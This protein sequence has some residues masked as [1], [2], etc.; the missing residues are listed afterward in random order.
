MSGFVFFGKVQLL[1][2]SAASVTDAADARYISVSGQSSGGSMAIQHLFAYSSQIKGAAIAAGSPYACGAF[3]EGHDDRKGN[4][5]GTCY[6]GGTNLQKAHEYIQQ[7]FKDGLI[8]NPANLK[9]IPVVVFNGKNDWCVYE[10]VSRDIIKQLEQYSGLGMIKRELGTRAAHVWSLDHFPSG[11][12]H[13][14]CGKCALY[15]K[16]S[17]PCCDFNNCHYDLSGD[18]LK[19]TYGNKM[20]KQRTTAT[21]SFTFINQRLYLPKQT[22]FWSNALVEKWAVAYVPSGCKGRTS[23]CDIHINYHGCINNNWPRRRMWVNGLDLNEY[24]EANN[25]IIIY[26]QAA[27]NKKTG[28]GCWNWGFPQFDQLYDTKESVQM[29]MVMNIVAHFRQDSTL[30]AGIDLPLVGQVGI[31]L[32]LEQGPPR[33]ND[34][35]IEDDDTSDSETVLV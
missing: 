26:P 9:S 16:Y 15:G 20:L 35:I 1:L 22:K 28:A 30:Q 27:G 14:T 12:K 3:P 5:T 25:I 2:A 10:Q 7:R 13:C 8:D 21:N 11:N 31:D 18:M 34:T 32:P 23:A 24:G 17:S 29:K 19:R 6:W 33:D 4:W